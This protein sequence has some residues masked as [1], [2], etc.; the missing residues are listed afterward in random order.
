M[1]CTILS[2]ESLSI[3]EENFTE[4]AKG[5]FEQQCL[6]F[7]TIFCFLGCQDRSPSILRGQ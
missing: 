1:Y 3:F 4:I 2:F 6:I 7:N 5:H